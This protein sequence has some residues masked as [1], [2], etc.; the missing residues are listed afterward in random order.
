MD[1]TENVTRKRKISS[2]ST[3]NLFKNRKKPN[4]N[5]DDDESDSDESVGTDDSEVSQSAEYIF[6]NNSRCWDCNRYILKDFQ[7]NWDF[8]IIFSGCCVDEI[9]ADEGNSDSCLKCD[10]NSIRSN[11]Q[12]TTCD[13]FLLDKDQENW[14]LDK[15]FSFLRKDTVARKGSSDKCFECEKEEIILANTEKCSKCNRIFLE[16][17]QEEWDIDEIIGSNY[18]VLIAYKGSSNK[19][20]DCEDEEYEEIMSNT[21]KCCKCG[22]IFLEEHQK[23]WNLDDIF[24]GTECSRDIVAH[25]GTSDMCFECENNKTISKLSNSFGTPGKY[26]KCENEECE[27]RKEAILSSTEK[28]NKCNRILLDEYQQEW[29][30][31][32]ILGDKYYDIVEG[33]G[34]SDKCMGCENEEFEEMMSN[35]EVTQ[36]LSTR[37]ESPQNFWN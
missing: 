1:S 22:R 36:K 32:K 35:A 16:K 29:D 30:I 4:K 11:E 24:N 23:E 26:D 12:C 13:R 20:V 25:K 6:E 2:D 14:D 7:Q 28:C 15:M 18:D 5:C 33:R 27:Y 37:F 8:D 9:I 10:E 3:E 34:C 17:Y 19:C 31:E 21:E